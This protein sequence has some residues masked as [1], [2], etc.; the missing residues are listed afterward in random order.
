MISGYSIRK[1]AEI[2]EID[3]STLFYWRYKIS[4]AIH[5]FLGIGH[6]EGIIEANETFFRESFKENHIKSLNLKMPRAS[7]K[8]T[9]PAS[10]RGISYEQICVSSDLSLDGKL[11]VEFISLIF[12]SYK[13][14]CKKKKCFLT[15]PYKKC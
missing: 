9:T 13:K 6:L 10:K 4:D 14:K 2:V 15:T 5:T 11:F 8:R 7:H 1:S 3:P 12:L